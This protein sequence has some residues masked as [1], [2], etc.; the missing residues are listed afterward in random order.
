VTPYDFHPEAALDLA[1]IWDSI[2]EDSLE[3]A[4]KVGGDFLARQIPFN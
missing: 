1:R 4:D 2:A 3:A